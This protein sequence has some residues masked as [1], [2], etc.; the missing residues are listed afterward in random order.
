MS[1]PHPNAPPAPSPL[2]E[3]P[4]QVVSKKNSSCN[5]RSMTT[6]SKAD[7]FRKMA[8]TSNLPYAPQNSP[9][10]TMMNVPGPSG[11][12]LSSRSGDSLSFDLGDKDMASDMSSDSDSPSPGQ[13]VP[14]S[15][16]PTNGT[17]R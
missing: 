3:E 15:T 9:T 6:A 2:E 7:C 8:E 17:P 12:P 13:R 11:L 1:S 10:R 5:P 16:P 4:W 14:D